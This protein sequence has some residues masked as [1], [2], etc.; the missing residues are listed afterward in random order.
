MSAT[1]VWRGLTKLSPLLVCLLLSSPAWGMDLALTG[2]WRLSSG[3]GE[4]VAGSDLPSS[5]ESTSGEMA[6]AVL[7]TTGTEDAWRVDISGSGTSWPAALHLFARRTGDGLGAGLIQDGGS[8]QELTA[9]SASFFSGTGD[10]TDIPLQ[11]RLTGVSIQIPPG[12]YTATV[13]CT[14]VDL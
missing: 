6:A 8:Y 7:N 3:P 1:G 14:V 13:V 2:A 11:L 4:V 12:N 10:R 5:Y 9:V